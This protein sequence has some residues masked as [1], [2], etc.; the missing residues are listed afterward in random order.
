MERHGM[1][2]TVFPAG[3]RPPVQQELPPS[4]RLPVAFTTVATP[5]EVD[6]RA[7]A[8]AARCLEPWAWPLV[9]LQ[10]LSLAPQEHVLL[11]HAHHVI[12]DGYSAALLMREL[13]EVYDRL[14][15]GSST[16]PL[17]PLRGDFRDHVRSSTQAGH[18]AGVAGRARER[19][20]ARVCART[21]RRCCG[22]P[23]AETARRSGPGP[24]AT[25]CSA[26]RSSP[27]KPPRRRHCGRSPHARGPPSTRRC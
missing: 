12:G 17:P 8:E 27:S 3:T 21:G 25:S 26:P 20:R 13:T 22:P 10:V 16:P 18:Q 7:A 9:R 15:G 5:A 1:L 2:R 4:L 6:E 23:S 24:T 19:R 14:T 11:V